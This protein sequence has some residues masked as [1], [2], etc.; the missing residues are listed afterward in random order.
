[1]AAKSLL[2][3]TLARCHYFGGRM[4]TNTF[5][6]RQETPW[7]PVPGQSSNLLPLQEKSRCKVLFLWERDK[8]PPCTLRT[9]TD[10]IQC[11]CSI[12]ERNRDPHSKATTVTR[13]LWLELAE[14]IGMVMLC[15]AC[16]GPRI[17]SQHAHVRE[18]APPPPCPPTHGINL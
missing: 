16:K 2:H 1:M 7:N 13:L 11:V 8:L 3:S 10:T 6:E 9:D 4:E 5:T 14:H 17:V 12:S 15:H 18:H